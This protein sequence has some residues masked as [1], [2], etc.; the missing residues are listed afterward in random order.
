MS[1]RVPSTF[2]ALPAGQVLWVSVAEALV[3]VWLD[4]FG[5][6]I[7]YL[8]L[9]LFLSAFVSSGSRLPWEP[10]WPILGTFLGSVIMKGMGGV[11]EGEEGEG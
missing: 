4:C 3:V 2:W 11:W 6:A 7:L 5:M 1:V 9:D 10:A 8:S